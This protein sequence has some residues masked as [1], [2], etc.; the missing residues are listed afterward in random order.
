PAAASFIQEFAGYC[1]RQ[2]NPFE[3]MLWLYG[4]SGTG[5]STVVKTLLRL[6]GDAGVAVNIDR[7]TEYTVASMAAAR[8]A[9]CTEMSPSML[10]T[11]SLKA[12]VSGDPVQG[13]HPYGRPF[14]V[15]YRGKF[16]CA[17]NSLPP[18]DEG[19]GLWRRLALVPFS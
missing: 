8:V 16:I 9:V 4:P 13:R 7:I 10:K 19:E 17:S 18:V 5:K 6:F 3:R 14:D 12:L 1:L 2:G 11:I 15:S